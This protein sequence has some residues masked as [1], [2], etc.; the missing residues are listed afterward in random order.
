MDKRE[1]IKIAGNCA[2]LYDSELNGRS[3]LIIYLEIGTKANI[4]ELVFREEQFMHLTGL[5][6]GKTLS[7]KRFYQKCL[8]NKLQENEFGFSARGTVNRGHGA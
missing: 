8:N 4:L 2:K 3:L 5:K 7:A 6:T 1:A